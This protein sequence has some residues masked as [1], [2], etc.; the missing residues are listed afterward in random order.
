MRKRRILTKEFWNF[1][2]NKKSLR[3]NR[4]PFYC[5]YSHNSGVFAFKLFEKADENNNSRGGK[6]KFRKEL[7]IGK[8]ENG[9]TAVK[10]KDKGNFEDDF[11]GNCKE[12]RKFSH[13]ASL[14]NADADEIHRKENHCKSPEFPSSI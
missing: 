6:N 5:L 14:I 2:K 7:G 13:S 12:E 10:N 1:L 9:K 11:T 8:S 3:K 4:R